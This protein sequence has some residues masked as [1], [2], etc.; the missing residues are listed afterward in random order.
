MLPNDPEVYAIVKRLNAVANRLHTLTDTLCTVLIALGVV[1]AVL[2][3][4]DNYGPQPHPPTER[5]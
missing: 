1:V 2:P 3:L 5:T 4:I